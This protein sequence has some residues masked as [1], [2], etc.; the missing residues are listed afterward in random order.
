MLA[1]TGCYY[2]GGRKELEE[3]QEIRKRWENLPVKLIKLCFDSMF[4]IPILVFLKSRNLW[5][6]WKREG[7]E[8]VP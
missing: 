7:K 8:N 3:F 1:F 6:P 2:G 5:I 4:L